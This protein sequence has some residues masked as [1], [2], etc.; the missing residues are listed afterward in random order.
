MAFISLFLADC[1]KY[2]NFTYFWYGSFAEILSLRRHCV[3]CTFWRNLRT[4]NLGKILHSVGTYPLTKIFGQE[5]RSIKACGY[6]SCDQISIQGK[7]VTMSNW[8][9]LS[10][11]KWFCQIRRSK[12]HVNFEFKKFLVPCIFFFITRV[13]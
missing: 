10:K 6:N 3:N 9:V 11:R 1:V 5:P 7:Y 12:I 4:R 8:Q 13:K 2:R